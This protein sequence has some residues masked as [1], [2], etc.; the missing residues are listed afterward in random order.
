M[1]PNYF[2]Y[3]RKDLHK[4]FRQIIETN[5][6]ISEKSNINPKIPALRKSIDNIDE[7]IKEELG[8][9]SFFTDIKDISST[10]ISSI[11]QHSDESLINFFLA[12]FESG[13]MKFHDIQKLLVFKKRGD[14]FY[15]YKQKI[16]ELIKDIKKIKRKNN[17]K[18][19][20]KSV[21][22]D[23]FTIETKK[24]I[25]KKFLKKDFN[26][27]D[28]FE[29][30]KE[31]KDKKIMEEKFI[32]TAD[33]VDI[34]IMYQ[35][36]DRFKTFVSS[37]T[38]INEIKVSF[39]N[40]VTNLKIIK[41]SNRKELNNLFNFNK[42]IIK[43]TKRLKNL[44]L[45]QEQLLKISEMKNIFITINTLLNS[46]EF[47]EALIL[48][49]KFK[50]EIETNKNNK[51]I[52]FFK[53]YFNLLSMNLVKFLKNNFQTHFLNY[54]TN[55]FEYYNQLNEN[56][57]I[58][59]VN[60]SINMTYDFE[61][62][63]LN[64]IISNRDRNIEYEHNISK[65]LFSLL[66]ISNL[67]LKGFQGKLFDIYDILNNKLTKDLEIFCNKKR[68]SKN[69]NNRYHFNSLKFFFEIH[70][71]SLKKF[72]QVLNLVFIENFLKVTKNKIEISEILFSKEFV[73]LENLYQIFLS[74]IQK[75]CNFFKIFSNIMIV[76][77][78]SFSD[79]KNYAVLF[80]E[81]KEKISYEIYGSLFP[82]IELKKEE[83]LI[84][85]KLVNNIGYNFSVKDYE[86]YHSNLESSIIISFHT[87]GINQIKLSLQQENWQEINIS[88]DLKENIKNTLGFKDDIKIKTDNVKLWL[89][90]KKYFISKS[91]AKTLSNINNYLQLLQLFPLQKNLLITFICD[92][93]AMYNN[94]SF[95]IIIEGECLKYKA[96]NKIDAYLLI[97]LQK[98]LELILLLTSTLMKHKIIPDSNK[99][100]ILIQDIDDHAKTLNGNIYSLIKDY[101]RIQSEK[102]EQYNWEED[103]FQFLSPS[104]ESCNII[105]YLTDM[106]KQIDQFLDK[107]EFSKM[108][109]NAVKIIIDH[110][111]SRMENFI[112]ISEQNI[113]NLNNE[114]KFII[115]NLDN[116]EKSIVTKK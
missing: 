54:F 36:I 113:Q 49:N 14:E 17:M 93:I 81:I 21:D 71:S 97:F 76:D 84:Y 69:Y 11:M 5:K 95:K 1:L 78:L 106:F 53:T 16:Y 64:W 39:E 31:E 50:N 13:Y 41:I 25:D 91:I 8:N 99:Y 116:L 65:S 92:T 62:D 90:E 22:L 87:L 112:Q 102:L 47:E 89:D 28:I 85:N 55:S 60:C 111:I 52:R 27:F 10:N 56:T 79:I 88:Y 61:V 115:E 20:T 67:S 7:N 110:Y 107:N 26:V 68:S 23:S 33:R 3:P 43:K 51:I 75:Y 29:Q 58:N 45:Y 72:L 12:P 109:D 108:F 74:L 42:K 104:I 37:L 40:C 9:S 80:K 44:K 70:F 18:V 96:I 57:L 48:Y 105:N 98:E 35:I 4:K 38:T 59:E 19:L 86:N 30:I 101:V 34:T 114:R 82:K 46:Q 103:V 32:Q 94:Y 24:R 83:I 2:K 73:I 63:N 66:Q 6:M 15:S 77:K 100:S